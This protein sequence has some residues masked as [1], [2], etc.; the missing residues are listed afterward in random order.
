MPFVLGRTLPVCHLFDPVGVGQ[1]LL[2][3]SKPSMILYCSL[4]GRM[5]Q[6]M[7]S[8]AQMG[9]FLVS[10]L[11]LLSVGF[12]GKRKETNHSWDPDFETN[13][14]KPARKWWG[15]AIGKTAPGRTLS[16]SDRTRVSRSW[17]TSSRWQREIRFLSF[18]GCQHIGALNDSSV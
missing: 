10:F 5:G 18:G 1:G 17:L 3:I 12:K 13:P 6:F 15:T 11:D 7:K 16:S 4:D 9:C 2:E 14:P 8:K